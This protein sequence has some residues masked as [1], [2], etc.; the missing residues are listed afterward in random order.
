[1][2]VK[3]GVRDMADSLVDHDDR[4]SVPATAQTIWW[5]VYPL[6]FTGA[7]IRP[8]TITHRPVHRLARIIHWLDYVADLGCD[9]LLLGPIFTSSTHGYDTLDFRSIDP[10]LGDEDDFRAL[11]RACHS[12]GISLML[13]GVFN[14]VGIENPLFRKELADAAAS[15]SAGTDRGR[16][17]SHNRLF[18]ITARDDGTLDYPVFE[19]H[20]D[21][22]VMDHESASTADLVVDVMD[23]WMDRGADAWRLDAAYA[24]PPRF[25]TQVLPRVR[26]NH[27]DAWFLGE[28][29]HG[30]YPAIIGESGMDSLTQYELWKAIW[31]SLES[32]NFYEL[33]WSL[34]RHDAFLDHFIPQTF[35]GNHDVTRIASK[36]GTP[37]A[38]IAALLL[39]TVGGT[40]SVYY[41]DELAL[42]GVKEDR[43]GGDDAV[44]P[45]FPDSFNDMVLTPESRGMRD[46]YRDII[47]M[48][49]DRPWLASAHTAPVEVDNRRYVYDVAPADGRE[50]ARDR[51]GSLRVIVELDPVPHATILEGDRTLLTVDAD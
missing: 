7:P 45:E 19:G 20:G 47:R 44:R 35:I 12:R 30:D 41:G 43:A 3:G 37:M 48:R 27:P 34:K 11:A 51:D 29:I 18:H 33:D 32:G 50:A 4:M 38:R 10:R 2:V 42:S 17:D 25:W 1:M 8:S 9:G 46:V 31:S 21:L 13:D 26:S 49:K 39:F 22:P 23:Y 28:V 5:Q 6:G 15:M 16:S 40:P 24:V 36:V 14:H